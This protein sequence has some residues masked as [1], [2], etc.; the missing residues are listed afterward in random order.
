M[1][2]DHFLDK[3][4]PNYG[5]GY[6]DGF[7]LDHGYHPNWPWAFWNILDKQQHLF[8]TNKMVND[9][10]PAEV[11]SGGPATSRRWDV[12]TAAGFC[13]PGEGQSDQSAALDAVGHARGPTCQKECQMQCR[14]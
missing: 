2:T 13:S 8:W 5:I 10:L 12:Q 9:Q 1:L 7:F 14:N 4:T 11:T 3:P 6:F